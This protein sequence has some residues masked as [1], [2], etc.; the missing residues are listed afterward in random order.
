MIRRSIAFVLI[1]S[2]LGCKAPALTIVSDP[3]PPPASF[4]SSS[5]S[6][7][8]ASLGWKQLFKDPYLQELIDT[9]MKNNFELASTLQETEIARYEAL[10]RKASLYPAVSKIG[11]AHV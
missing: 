8:T 2:I 11:R 9:A 3:A 7:N 6:T 5:D 1:I 4:M 10:Y